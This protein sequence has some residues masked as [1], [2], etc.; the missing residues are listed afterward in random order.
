MF[1]FGGALKSFKFNIIAFIIGF[2]IGISYIYQKAPIIEEK[3]VF[4]T[5]YNSGKLTYKNNNGDCFQYI[6]E[7]IDC[8]EDTTLIKQ[9]SVDSKT[10]QLDESTQTSLY[11]KFKK[12]FN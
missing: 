7:K 5:P 10:S 4:P 11:D 6:A 12:M 8:P 9:H 3:V 2:I 1:M